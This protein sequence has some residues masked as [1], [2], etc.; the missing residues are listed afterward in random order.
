[1]NSKRNYT[2]QDKFVSQYKYIKAAAAPTHA[3]NKWCIKSTDQVMVRG[4]GI[5]FREGDIDS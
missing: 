1:M 5:V 4:V 3:I 2:E